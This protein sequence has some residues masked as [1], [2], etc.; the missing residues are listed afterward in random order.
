[1]KLEEMPKYVGFP[2]DKKIYFYRL[3]LTDF[4]E[5]RPRDQEQ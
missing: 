4:A 2:V 3:I 1:M 5:K